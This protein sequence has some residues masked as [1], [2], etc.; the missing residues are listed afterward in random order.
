[1]NWL[2]IKNLN[3]TS[4]DK[5]FNLF[6][7]E[8]S[9]NKN[10]T[11]IHGS[12][13]IGKTTFFKLLLNKLKFQSGELYLNKTLKTI[14]HIDQHLSLLDYLS[15]KENCILHANLQKKQFNKSEFD[16]NFIE[17][18]ISD[19]GIGVK[20][21]NIDKIFDKFYR[22]P[23]GNIHNVKGFGLGLSYVKN[24]LNKHNATISVESVVNKGT[25][26][27]IRIKNIKHG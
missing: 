7:P 10:K 11:L 15:I 2:T 27:K 18:S 19:Q 9:L 25:I 3:Y 5:L 20:K 17:I 16:K 1:M 14:V 13:G 6:I 4:C 12:N 24:I 21:S 8:L 22:E 23:Q 26:F